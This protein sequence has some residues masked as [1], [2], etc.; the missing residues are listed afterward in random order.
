MRIFLS[1]V[2]LSTSLVYGCTDFA[3]QAKDGTWVIGRSLE[4][5]TELQNV[6][7][8]FPRKQTITSLN[9]DKKKGLEW[10]SKYGYLGITCFG[11]NLCLEGMNEMGLTFGFLWLPGVT[12]YPSVPPKE[13]K[14]ALDFVDF[15]AWVLGNFSTIGEV[16]EALKNIRVWGHPVPPLPG[17]PPVH[18]ALH[19]L[20]GQHLVIE[21]IGGVMKVHDNPIGILTNSPPF[22]WQLANLQNYLHLNA[23]NADPITFR[24]LNLEPPGQGSGLLGIPGDWTP[25][26]RFIKTFT[27][28]RFATSPA[29][30]SEAINLSQHL[31]NTLD[32]PLGTVREKGKET[33]DYTQWTVIK[34]LKNKVFYFRSYKDLNLKMIDMKKLNFETVTS[35]TI[36]IDLNKGVIDVTDNF[37][38]M[39]SMTV[40]ND[41]R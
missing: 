11:T 20:K 5:A 25:P 15:G 34:D 17:T 7:K 10:T 2:L 4:F 26:S 40:S 18:V 24:G 9:P 14:Q 37:S 35:K 31:L 27:Y 12:Q 22:D 19:D 36:P 33:G 13:M 23:T 8:V 38:A 32:I 39:V 30:A 28:L 41:E 16:K 3:V 29:N 6:F 21:F 1:L